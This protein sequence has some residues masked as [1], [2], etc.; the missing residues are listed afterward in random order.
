MTHLERIEKPKPEKKRYYKSILITKGNILG[1][2]LN[3]TVMKLL[4]AVSTIRQLDGD[5]TKTWLNGQWVTVPQ[6]IYD[7]FNYFTHEVGT[8]MGV[9]E[10][11]QYDVLAF[12]CF[13][14]IH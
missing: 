9:L 4:S 8:L 14:I 1:A 3:Q 10:A 13:A 7:F 11:K 6:Q 5:D 12:D 2:L